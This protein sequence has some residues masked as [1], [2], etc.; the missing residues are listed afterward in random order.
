MGTKISYHNLVVNTASG[1][2]VQADITVYQAS[3]EDL[4]IIY[5][6]SDGGNQNNP[7]QTDSAGRFKFYADPGEYDIKISGIDINEYTLGGITI[8][9]FLLPPEANC[10]ITNL[11]YD[12]SNDRL[13]I[14]Y[15]DKPI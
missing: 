8:M 12:P 3:T 14:K 5:S 11:Y 4:V 10:K 1:G 9:G 6:D 13:I 7:F 15:D 2:G